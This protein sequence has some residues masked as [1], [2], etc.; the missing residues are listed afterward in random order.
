MLSAQARWD[1]RVKPVGAL[2]RLEEVVCR[3]CGITGSDTP[4]IGRKRII[5]FAADHGFA[6]E[7]FV[8]GRQE[9]TVQVA[10]RLLRGK[11]AIC[12]L[13]RELGI[14]LRL[15]DMGMASILEDPQMIAPRLGSGTRNFLQEPAMSRWEVERALDV[16]MEIA[17]SARSEG[18]EMIAGVGLGTGNNAAASAIIAAL[19]RI[20]PEVVTPSGLGMDETHRSLKVELL[21]VALE[22]WRIPPDQPLEILRHFGGFEVA[23]LTGMYFGAAAGRMPVIVDGFLCTVAA[24]VAMRVDPTV[25]D[26]LIFAHTSAEKGYDTVQARL[27]LHPLL[28]LRIGL[29]EGVG[30]A[31]AMKIIDA[32]R[33]LYQEMPGYGLSDVA[34]A[35]VVS[36]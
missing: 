25:R 31:L 22:R 9:V 17:E 27:D 36:A 23:A 18:V 14:E 20:D 7:G 11:A 32:A 29:G 26:Y 30:A 12:I 19:L 2:G 16:G 15:V 10:R 21:R 33:A 28:D 34:Q 6:R 5:M 13:A 24:A 1:T 3:L 4:S 8:P 35:D